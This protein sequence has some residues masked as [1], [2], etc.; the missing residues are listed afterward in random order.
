MATDLVATNSLGS[1]EGHGRRE[2]RRWGWGHKGGGRC[3][4]ERAPGCVREESPLAEAVAGD[5]VTVTG[6]LGDEAFRGRVMAMGILPGVTLTVVRGGRR[7]PLLVALPGSRCVVDERSS[8]MITVR[9][10]RPG[11]RRERAWQ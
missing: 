6:I 1:G 9:R 5:V 8:E 3:R 11:C 10:G 7:Q 4:A 2:R